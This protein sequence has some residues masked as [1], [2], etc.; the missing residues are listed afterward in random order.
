MIELYKS[1][2]SLKYKKIALKFGAEIAFYDQKYNKDKSLDIDFM[3]HAAKYLK[4]P[5]EKSF[6]IV[7]PT[8]PPNWKIVD[9]GIKKFLKNYKNMTQ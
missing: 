5:N 1:A 2:D 4:K 9:K 8:T 3:L 6:H 7:R